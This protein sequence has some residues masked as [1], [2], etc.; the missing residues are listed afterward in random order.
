MRVHSRCSNCKAS[1]SKFTIYDTRVEYE[2]RKGTKFV[3]I[4][5]N[6]C[7]NT[8]EYHLNNLRAVRS[9]FFGILFVMAIIAA[10]FLT[11]FTSYF[12]AGSTFQ[13]TIMGMISG[14]PVLA[15]GILMRNNMF[16]V[17]AFNRNF[18]R[19]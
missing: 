6:K 7:K 17:N 18:V 5:C 3:S 11:F 19:E 2:M 8:D 10:I 12:T 15:C 4:Q 16:K 13:W 9:P 1:I 14:V